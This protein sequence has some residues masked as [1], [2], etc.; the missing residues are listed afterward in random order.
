[1]TR[2]VTTLL[3]TAALLISVLGY[4]QPAISANTSKANLFVMT[5]PSAQLKPIANTH[6]GY[7]LTLVGMQPH[8]TYFTEKPQRKTGT[9]TMAEFLKIW[10]SNH[11]NEGNKQ[12]NV[13]LVSY[14][15][16]QQPLVY[17]FE[18]HNP[19][20]DVVTGKMQFTAVAIGDSKPTIH[21]LRQLKQASL[22]IDDID[23]D[24]N[25]FKPTTTPPP[26]GNSK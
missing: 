1:M 17:V 9:T 11:L 4:T 18:V 6:H 5:A 2:K 15:D 26:S 24:G 16:S 10:Q 7:E 12:P 20:Y 8:V 25:I 23:W 3:S 13:S 14:A 21:Q 19:R 22:F